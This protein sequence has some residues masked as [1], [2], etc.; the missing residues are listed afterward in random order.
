MDDTIS[1]YEPRTREMYAVWTHAV[2]M[3]AVYKARTTALWAP[4]I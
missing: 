4:L 2:W 3:H 1:G